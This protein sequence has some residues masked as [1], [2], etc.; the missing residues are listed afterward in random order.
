MSQAISRALAAV[1]AALLVPVASADTPSRIQPYVLA[2]TAAGDVAAEVAKVKAK[3]VAA[4]FEIVG[5]YL[6]YA[7][8]DVICITSPELKA[9]AAK[10]RYGAF[11]VAERVAVTQAGGA[12]QVSYLNPAYVAGA[13]QLGGDLAE[14]S[15]KLKSA[16]GAEKMYG[17]EK[18]RTVEELRGYHYLVGMEYLGD[19][20]KLGSYKSHDEAVRTV[21]EN[22]K[23][24]VGGAAQVYRI[25]IPGKAQTVFGISRANVTDEAANERHIMAE[26]VDRKFDLKTTAYLPYELL[27]DGNSAVALHMRFRMAAW[28]PDLTMGTFGQL[29]SSPGAIEALLAKV[30]GGEKPRASDF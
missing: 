29:V 7:G 21:E 13:Y 17:T 20:Y 8:A 12:L 5:D 30:A 11:A 4:G 1:G 10:D 27:V 14:V 2:Y 23:K 9:A 6:P 15:A 3:L 24:S 26:V 16:L 19:V 22:L 25:D 18:G 28:H